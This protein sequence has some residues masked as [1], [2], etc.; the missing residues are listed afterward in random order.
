[1][2]D[3]P[4][5][6]LY[7]YLARRDKKEIKVLTTFQGH[8]V[9]PTRVRDVK[10]LG[11]PRELTAKLSQEI[12]EDRLLWEPWVEAADSF[13]Q[14]RESLKK[15]GYK[16]PRR[17]KSRFAPEGLIESN[18][19]GLDKIAPSPRTQTNRMPIRK[20]MLGG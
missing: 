8:A 17:S 3:A 14:L 12:H 18:V 1:M 15:R 20:T 16:A 7:L 11:L 19:R 6:R 2:R 5:S 13:E 4:T 10:H 9:P